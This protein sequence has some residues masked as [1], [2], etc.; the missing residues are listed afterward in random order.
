MSFL[1]M[2]G[3]VWDLKD[4]RVHPEMAIFPMNCVLRGFPRACPVF[5]GA[6]YQMYALAK[7]LVRPCSSKKLL[8]SELDTYYL[9]D[10]EKIIFKI[11]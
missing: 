6:T 9:D 7:T 4:N 10:I 8:I 11:F 3:F 5:S 1:S 2:E